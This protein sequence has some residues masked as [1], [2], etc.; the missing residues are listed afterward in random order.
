M[1]D[2]LQSES[3]GNAPNDTRDKDDRADFVFVFSELVNLTWYL[4]DP[5][6]KDR[7]YITILNLK[8]LSF[9]P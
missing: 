3:K 2:K 4:P 7:L 6:Y 5:R 9:G 8:G 1:H